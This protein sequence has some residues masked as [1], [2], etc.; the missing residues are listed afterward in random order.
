[1]YFVVCNFPLS[2]IRSSRRICY[3]F[4]TH[5]KTTIHASPKNTCTALSL[6]TFA[7][8]RQRNNPAIQYSYASPWKCACD[9]YTLASA[10][11]LAWGTE[12]PREW[13]RVPSRQNIF[14]LLIS[15][16][17]QPDQPP[18]RTNPNR[19]NKSYFFQIKNDSFPVPLP[20]ALN[21]LRHD[22]NRCRGFQHHQQTCIHST[23][24]KDNGQGS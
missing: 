6:G 9:G 12:P 23:A 16:P 15:S 17:D 22:F 13:Q 10:S 19:T 14:V 7:W 3:F 4:T 20:K 5:L 1:M 2:L 11:T 24:G 21:Q 8:H 18:T